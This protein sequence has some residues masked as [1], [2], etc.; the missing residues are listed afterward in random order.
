MDTNQIIQTV[1]TIGVA[2]GLKI[3]GAIVVWVVGR[4]LIHLVVRLVSA[5]ASPTSRLKL[6]GGC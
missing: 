5:A 6:G 3:A 2:F 1:T 4:Y